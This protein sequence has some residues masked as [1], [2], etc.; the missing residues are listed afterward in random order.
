MASF[1]VF[2]SH[3]VSNQPHVANGLKVDFM[4][5]LTSLQT[6]N[7]SDAQ[8]AFMAVKKVFLDSPQ[9]PADEAK[10]NDLIH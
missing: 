1:S 2:A 3:P 9:T 6:G 5:W 4:T 10:V 7:N 8:E